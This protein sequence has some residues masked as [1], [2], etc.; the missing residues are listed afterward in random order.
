[1]V[2]VVYARPVCTK[3]GIFVELS[4]SSYELH[5]VFL[6]WQKTL[7]QLT[8]F[9]SA[10]VE[11][12]RLKP[13]LIALK[14]LDGLPN[15][16]RYRCAALGIRYFKGQFCSGNRFGEGGKFCPSNRFWKFLTKNV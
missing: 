5:V 7:V 8:I 14:D 9:T 13:G 2:D 15:K 1:M 4:T 3:F 16:S 11:L 10:K 12:H 6:L